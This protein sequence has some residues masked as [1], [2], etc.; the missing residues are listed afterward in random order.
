[1][2]KSDWTLLVIAAAGG[3]T[4]TPIQLQKALFLIGNTMPTVDEGDFYVFRPY[5]YGPFCQ[6]IYSDAEHL[7]ADGLINIVSIPNQSWSNYSVTETGLARAK[8]LS[9]QLDDPQF[10]YLSSLVKWV[11]G[12]SFEQLLSFVYEKYPKFAENSVFGV[13]K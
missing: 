10:N 12:L 7:Y 1:M 11:K 6:N 3:D 13:K 2:D 5:N 8:M 9:S 4:L